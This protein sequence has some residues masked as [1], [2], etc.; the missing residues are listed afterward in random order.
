MLAWI[1]GCL[2]E[3]SYLLRIIVFLGIA[4]TGSEI[5]LM[6]SEAKPVLVPRLLEPKSHC[7]FSLIGV[8]PYATGAACFSQF[9]KLAQ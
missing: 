7:E 8:N 3:A 5:C 1:L 9:S 4:Y 6:T 2:A